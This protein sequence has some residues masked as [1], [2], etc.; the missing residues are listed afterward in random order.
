VLRSATVKRSITT[1][2]A[3]ALFLAGCVR[4]PVPLLTGSLSCYAGGESGPTGRL[5]VDPTYGTSF[6]GQPVMWPEGYT[7]RRAG[8][9]VEVL[10]ANG[11]VKAT[12]G[13]TYH[14]SFAF[15]PALLP[16]DDGSFDYAG[17]T[18]AF[19]AAVD[20]GYAWDFIDC[21]AAPADRYCRAQ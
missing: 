4:E 15:A 5:V 21:T 8:G 6:N 13:R 2:L 20:C 9:E 1:T 18:N 17:P 10:D 3:L 12:T 7:A 14:I 16:N 19:P 11:N